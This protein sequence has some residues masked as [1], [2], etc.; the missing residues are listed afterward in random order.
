ML[1]RE[2]SMYAGKEIS[3]T[4]KNGDCYIFLNAVMEYGLIIFL[5]AQILSESKKL[6]LG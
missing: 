5:H 3:S 2:I 6:Y 4:K 1:F